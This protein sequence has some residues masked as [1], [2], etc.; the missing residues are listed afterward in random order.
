MQLAS[1]TEKYNA[2][3]KEL[4]EQ[5]L[6]H[7]EMS[8]DLVSYTQKEQHLLQVLEDCKDETSGKNRRSSQEDQQQIPLLDDVR[9]QLSKLLQSEHEL[10]AEL[11]LTQTRLYVVLDPKK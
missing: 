11:E 9:V 4:E 3:L 8:N 6:E 1:L 7:A 10:T 5:A 2:T